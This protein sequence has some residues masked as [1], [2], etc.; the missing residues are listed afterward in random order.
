MSPTY[1]CV[2]T[3]MLNERGGYE[4]DCTV[5]RLSDDA[6]LVVSPTGAATRD[7]D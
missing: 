1:E 5:T 2:Y 4:S 3:G 6:F 7:A